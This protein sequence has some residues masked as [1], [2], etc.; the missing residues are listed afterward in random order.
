MA[1]RW[2]RTRGI[3]LGTLEALYDQSPV[4][5]ER[6]CD[7]ES[8]CH[9]RLMGHGQKFAFYFRFSSKPLKGF[10]Q[11]NGHDPVYDRSEGVVMAGNIRSEIRPFRRS[12]ACLSDAE[13]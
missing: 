1:R 6:V 10:K 2:I 13:V 12:A 8:L 7:L 9:S 5:D 3:W 11:R 4:N